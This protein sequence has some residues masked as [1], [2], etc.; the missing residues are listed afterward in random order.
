MNRRSFLAGIAAS[1]AATSA[2]AKT[3]GFKSATIKKAPAA[4][5]QIP[6]MKAIRKSLAAKPAVTVTPQMRSSVV[7]IKRKKA[8]RHIAP[9]IDIQAINFAFG[10]AE[11]PYQEHWKVERIAA[12]LHDILHHSPDELFL[13]EGHTDAVGSFGS[14]MRLS[15]RRAR[16]LQKLLMYQFGVPGY[17]LE[18]VGFGEDEL[19]VP[20]PYAEWRNRRVTLRRITDIV[21][22]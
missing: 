21:Y 13:I 3:P 15:R 6:S 16:S 14:N 12:A 1:A 8:L 5:K 10:S 9:S 18:T 22:Q 7:D 11:I 4:T 17:A 2:F 19:L 20:T